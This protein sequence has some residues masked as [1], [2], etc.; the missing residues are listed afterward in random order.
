M[1]YLLASIIPLLYCL[2]CMLHCVW[3][4]VTLWTVAHQAPVSMTFSR[5]EY[6]SRLPFPFPGNLPDSGIK[7][8]SSVF[9]ALQEDSLLTEPS[10]KPLVIY[11][12][13]YIP[14]LYYIMLFKV[15]D[16]L[17]SV[18]LFDLTRV[19]S[20]IHMSISALLGCS[21][22]GVSFSLLSLSTCLFPWTSSR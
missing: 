14:L 20:D 21:L 17:V 12:M 5:Q 4:F 13:L 6:W 15:F 2:A 8:T 22:H 9:L 11:L 19:A 10:G 16:V 7:P 3:H 1:F 18:T